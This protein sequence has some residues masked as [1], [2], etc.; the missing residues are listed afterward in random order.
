MLWL[1]PFAI[2]AL[3]GP[4]QPQIPLLQ[5]EVEDL[6]TS[7][8]AWMALRS[9][10]QLMEHIASLPE[11]RLVRYMDEQGQLVTKLITEG[12]KAM[13]VLNGIKFA[14]VSDEIEISFVK[15]MSS[16]L[17]ATPRLTLCSYR[18]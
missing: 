15:R 6:K 17:M 9:H 7:A 8:V 1:L 10:S 13:L 12:H 14:D 3:A 16:R 2:V 18:T 11:P 5:N 4:L